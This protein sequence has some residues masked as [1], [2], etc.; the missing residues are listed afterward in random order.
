MICETSALAI[1][2]DAQNA[3]ESAVSHFRPAL[4]GRILEIG[5]NV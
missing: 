5:S 3:A 4:L 1:G 2:P